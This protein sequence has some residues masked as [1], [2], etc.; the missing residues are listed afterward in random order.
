M[1]F[2]IYAI[3]LTHGLRHV[4]R[5]RDWLA[6]SPG[7]VAVRLV[8]AAVIVGAIQT[9][10]VVII[11]AVWTQTSPFDVRRDFLLSL[12][13]SATSAT[14]IWTAIYTGVASLR[15]AWRARQDA[16]ALELGLREARLKALEAQLGPHFLF[17]CLNSLRG[18]IAEDPTGAQAMATQLA[19]I[20]RH[21]LV[22]HD[23]PT[24]TLGE[25]LEF[26]RDYLALE[27]VRFEE[28]LRTRFDVDPATRASDL[29]AM[30]LQTLVEN[31]LKH[32][33]AH[34]PEGGEI[35][36]ASHFEN[37]ELVVTVEN[38]G[39]LTAPPDDSTRVGLANLRERLR[40]LHG[41]DASLDIRSSDTNTVRA[42]VR[43]P[44][45][46]APPAVSRPPLVPHLHSSA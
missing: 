4:I 41:P 46:A 15:R 40:V 6:L 21:N 31:A 24:E 33:I 2:L 43:V 26:T 3:A 1:L 19:N 16:L 23:R 25:Q 17:N 44:R 32:G 12:W 37:D 30:L 18:R 11:E 27:S 29:P 13:I 10:L 36:I 7:R 20:L 45:A 42:T 8:A 34:L 5:R 39:Q 28:R 9:A 14:S 22:R 38:S 35:A